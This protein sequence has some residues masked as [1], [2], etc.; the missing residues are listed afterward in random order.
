MNTVTYNAQFVLPEVKEWHITIGGSG[1]YQTSKNKAEEVLIP[2]YSL[3]DIGGFIYVQRYF[4]KLTLSGGARYDHRSL[5]QK[6]F[7]MARS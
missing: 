4:K 7:L 1:M 5:I 2:E 6:N 3:F